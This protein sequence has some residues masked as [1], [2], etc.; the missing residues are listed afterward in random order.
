MLPPVLIPPV[1]PDPVPELPSCVVAHCC[2]PHPARLRPATI[3]SVS[4]KTLFATFI[5]SS[6]PHDS[7]VQSRLD[8]S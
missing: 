1:V 8:H 2:F 6:T 7:F 4:K 5:T 3:A